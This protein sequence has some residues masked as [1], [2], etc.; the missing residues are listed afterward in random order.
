MNPYDVN[1]YFDYVN[2]ISF[3]FNYT[4]FSSEFA[5]KFNVTKN[6]LLYLISIT[7][8][9]VYVTGYQFIKYLLLD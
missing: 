6:K 1:K 8:L 3:D 9:F 7:I 4:D 5:K 2:K